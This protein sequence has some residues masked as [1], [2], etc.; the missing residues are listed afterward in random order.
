MRLD[1]S[2]DRFHSV[3]G[4]TSP[5]FD[6]PTVGSDNS[7][8][9]QGSSI[10]SVAGKKRAPTKQCAETLDKDS[11]KNATPSANARWHFEWRDIKTSPNGRGDYCDGPGGPRAITR[12]AEDLGGLLS[13]APENAVGRACRAPMALRRCRHRRVGRRRVEPRSKQDAIRQN[14]R[15]NAC[16]R[17]ERDCRPTVPGRLGRRGDKARKPPRPRWPAPAARTRQARITGFARPPH[18]RRQRLTGA[19]RTA[20]TSWQI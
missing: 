10:A 8:A 7:S 20:W 11:K 18:K 2:A 6:Q 5:V 12:E 1:I 15:C 17:N 13:N 4:G 19:D 3:S 9:T 14:R 16:S